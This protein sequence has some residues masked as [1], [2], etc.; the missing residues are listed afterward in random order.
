MI[1][2]SG[3]LGGRGSFLGGLLG[4]VIIHS[5]GMVGMSGETMVVIVVTNWAIWGPMGIAVPGIFG[6]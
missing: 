2:P 6:E 4:P 5:V 1:F 3:F